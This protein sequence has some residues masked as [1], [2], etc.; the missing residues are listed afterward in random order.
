LITRLRTSTWFLGFV[1]FL[2]SW[3]VAT[4]VP[5][6]GLDASWQAGLHMAAHQRIGFGDDLIFSYGPL[7]FLNFP[8]LYYPAT[9]A[10]AGLYVATVQLGVSVS[11]VWAARQMM[12]TSLAFGF[13]LFGAS[14]LFQDVIVVP[15][16]IWCVATVLDPERSPVRRVLPAAAGIVAGIEVLGKL[17][18]GVMVLALLTLTLV[19]LP[20]WRRNL[21][22]FA[23]TFL[24]TLLAGWFA[25]GGALT[26]LWPY[27][28]NA[29]SILSGYS[30]AMQYDD[31]AS[32]SWLAVLLFVGIGFVAA[33]QSSSGA[34]R[35]SR[36]TVLLLWS[37]FAFTAFKLGFVRQDAG[38]KTL[39][40]SL[41]VGGLFAFRWR[42]ALRVLA[43]VSL[44]GAIALFFSVTNER[45]SDVIKPGDRVDH[46]F[47]QLKTM[48]IPGRRRDLR[49]TTIASIR[50]RYALDEKTWALLRGKTVDV[51]PQEATAA[52]AHDLD[53][54]PLPVFQ[55][56]TAFT[57]RLDRLNADALSSSKGPELILRR[58][59]ETIDSRNG[60]FE[61]PAAVIAMVCH[62]E[63]VRAT[64]AWEVLKRVPDRCGSA[65]PVGS[66]KPG[67]GESVA[68]PQ[69]PSSNEL[70][71]A[72]VRGIQVSGAERIRALLYRAQQRTVAING[73]G[74]RFIPGTADDGL[75]LTIPPRAD[76]SAPYG[77]SLFNGSVA[78]NAGQIAFFRG[79]PT[80]VQPNKNLEIDFYEM[81]IRSTSG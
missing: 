18:I 27:A 80:D 51:Y 77:F 59:E 1:V 3:P 36:V 47:N 81:L 29:G 24:A 39:F 67:L 70:V 53:W 71:F 6:T 79:Q 64:A 49:N 55:S 23:P 63:E 31:S 41:M 30:S 19:A 20:G 21:S 46:G 60:A 37:L 74:F 17:N 50:Q 76:Y 42:P 48:L 12:P 33:H 35:R 40:F 32:E 22:I 34:G 69:P 10:L 14:I 15:V 28:L 68:V 65:R 25:T 78:G 56:Y 26:D 7:G 62:Y 44:A 73:H 75:L 45:F 72:R 66:L 54:R 13:A 38:H 52:W 57:E 4:L 58:P 5:G 8:L 61:S 2:A 11:L 9:A 16:L 43:I